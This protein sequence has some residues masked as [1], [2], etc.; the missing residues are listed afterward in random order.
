[1]MGRALLIV[2]WVAT[3]GLVATAVAGY[4]FSAQAV[5]IGTHL[6]TALA[7]SLLLLFSHCWIMFYLIG[8][9]KAIREAVTE[10]GL[11]PELIEK[12]KAFKNRSYPWLMLAMGIVMTTF[13]IGGG[14]YT[15]TLPALVHHGLFY[16]AI[17]VQV[18]T[19]VLERA[20]LLENDILMASIDRRLR[21]G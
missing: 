20:V 13:I 12:T 6:A 19:L 1:M 10:H 17:V 14:V 8:T 21:A 18:R 4:L 11:E 5:G 3:I 16:A 9:G 7:S 15:R 2:G